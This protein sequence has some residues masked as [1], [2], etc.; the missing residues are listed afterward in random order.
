MDLP[1]RAAV[2]MRPRATAESDMSIMRG[3]A[4]RRG[5]VAASGF[6]PKS[7]RLPPHAGIAAGELPNARPAR[8]ASAIG[9]R[10]YAA[11]PKWLLLVTATYAAP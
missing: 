8:V 4:P 3:G 5:N 10:W 2:M 11:T 6:V 7:A 1:S 9:S